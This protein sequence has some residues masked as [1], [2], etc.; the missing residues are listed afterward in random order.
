M[1]GPT[2]RSGLLGQQNDHVAIRSFR[3]CFDKWSLFYFF[4]FFSGQYINVDF[5]NSFKKFRS[6]LGLILFGII[7]FLFCFGHVG[8]AVTVEVCRIANINTSNSTFTENKVLPVALPMAQLLIARP[9]VQM[10]ASL[11]A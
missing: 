4:C 7:L 6:V 2:E 11:V 5:T 1:A 3:N 10:I 8:T 9:V